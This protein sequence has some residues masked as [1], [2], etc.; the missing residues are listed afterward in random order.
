MTK[1]AVFKYGRVKKDK[2]RGTALH[3]TILHKLEETRK[4]NAACDLGIGKRAIRNF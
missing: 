3:Y 2:A 4:L 1:E